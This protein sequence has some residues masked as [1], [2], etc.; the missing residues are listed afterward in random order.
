MTIYQ[1]SIKLKKKQCDIDILTQLR[2]SFSCSVFETT[3]GVGLFL[4]FIKNM[5]HNEFINNIN[6]DDITDPST[7]QKILIYMED[8]QFQDEQFMEVNVNLK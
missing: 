7:M 3:A 1:R 2:G 5:E 8:L 6:V 4:G